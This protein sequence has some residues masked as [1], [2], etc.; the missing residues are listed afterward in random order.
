MPDDDAAL[1]A[2]RELD[3]ALAR[4]GAELTAARDRAAEVMRE[5]ES[6]VAWPTIA[7]NEPQPVLVET[8]SGVLEQLSAAGSRFRRAEAVALHRAGLSMEQIAA[9]FGVTRQRVSALLRSSE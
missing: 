4:T 7:A 6:G 1:S 3:S 2:L 5:R 9:L 8:V